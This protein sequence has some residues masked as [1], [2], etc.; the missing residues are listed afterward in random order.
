MG[1]DRGL[2]AAPVAIGA[3]R[4]LRGERFDVVHVHHPMLLGPMGLRIARDV[5]REDGVHRSL[6]VHATTSTHYLAG[7]ARPLKRAAAR[8]FRRFARPLRPGRGTLHARPAPAH[9]RVGRDGARRDAGGRGR[10]RLRPAAD[11]RRGAHASSG[12]ARPPGS[13][14]TSAR[15]A[16]EKRVE[17]VVREFA[18]MVPLVPAAE[19]AIVGDGAGRASLTRLA[20]RLGVR[21]RVACC[22]RWSE[23]A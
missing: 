22:P 18:S 19:L 9:A 4:E 2:P 6:R 17:T 23:T 20:E 8:R 7:L 11:A 13:R 3:P 21:D 15:L 10:H 5:R 14:S 12:S 1:F 16:P